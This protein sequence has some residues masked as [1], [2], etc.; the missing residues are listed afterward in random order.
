MLRRPPSS[1]LFPYTTLFRSAD[2]ASGLLVPLRQG[3]SA[4]CQTVAVH[5]D[6]IGVGAHHRKGA[7]QR[8]LQQRCIVLDTILPASRSGVEDELRLLGGVDEFELQPVADQH[9]ALGSDVQAA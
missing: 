4:E 1:T 6:E 9:I 3:T 5:D 2:P 8:S 7:R